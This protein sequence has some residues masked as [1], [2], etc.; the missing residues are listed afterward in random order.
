M[1][2]TTKI[3]MKTKYKPEF[4]W[5][6]CILSTAIFCSFLAR[7]LLY[8]SKKL[9]KICLPTSTFTDEGIEHIGTIWDRPNVGIE[10]VRVVGLPLAVAYSMQYAYQKEKKNEISEEYTR[11]Q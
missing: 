10:D 8:L 5:R 6:L 11:L 3:V 4:V 1:V 9:S 2:H 7:K